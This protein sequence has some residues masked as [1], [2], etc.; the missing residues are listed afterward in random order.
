MSEYSRSITV[1]VSP[2]EVQ[3]LLNVV[4]DTMLLA[5]LG[6]LADRWKHD[7]ALTAN[8]VANRMMRAVQR[9]IGANHSDYVPLA[10]PAGTGKSDMTADVAE[11]FREATLQGWMGE[12]IGGEN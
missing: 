5:R 1:T 11:S 12:W 3:A 8:V 6:D 2:A 7:D 10:P 4:G 9:E